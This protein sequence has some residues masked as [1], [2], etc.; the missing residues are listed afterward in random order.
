[1]HRPEAGTDTNR[2]AP[3]GPDL[4]HMAEADPHRPQFHF[5]SPAGWLN[6]PNGVGQWDGVYHLFYQYNPSA[7]V[8]QR[9]HWGH[10]T[11]R[12]LITWTDQP[13]AL[14]PDSSGPDADGCWSGVLIDDDRSPSLLYSGHR[15]GNDLQV[16]CLATGSDDLTIWTKHPQN[17]V[18]TAPP[19]LNLVAFRDHCVWRENGSWRQLVG[20]GIRGLGGAALLFESEDLRRWRYVGPL[21]VGDIRGAGQLGGEPGTVTWTGA[22]WECI[23]LFRLGADGT[24]TAPGAPGASSGTDVLVFSA[25]DQDTFH[26]LCYTG[27]YDGDH[28]TPESLHR[29]DLGERVFY[30]PQSFRD[31][32]GRRIVFGWI[33]E[34]RPESECIAV[35]WSG[36]MS[37][38][39][40]ATWRAG[41]VHF[42]PAPEVAALRTE[43]CGIVDEHSP[44]VLSPG[45]Y[46]DGPSGPQLDLDFR[47]R[48][49]PGAQVHVTVLASQAERT[50]IKIRR[51]ATDSLGQ[52]SLDRSVASSNPQI[53]SAGREGSFPIGTDDRV[54]LRILID[55]SV[56]EIFANG[57][58]LTARVYPTRPEDAVGTTISTPSIEGLTEPIVI[59]RFDAWGMRSIWSEPRDMWP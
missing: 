8:H 40:I 11:S 25:W 50:V 29:F 33:Q 19:E 28:F 4:V 3:T 53:R 56:L 7:P 23:D 10:A 18:V 27:T 31:D 38:P 13:I 26:T 20:S 49:P 59:E 1:M 48:V 52:L 39:R 37:L 5:V 2:A 12:D 24:S 16:G 57:Q 34:E 44:M 30:A 58:P 54:H 46:L 45:D 51:T 15:D 35:G 32:T 36:A 43:H 6:D 21:A 22:V 17:P 14:A 9:I 55:R 42:E 41:A 47:L